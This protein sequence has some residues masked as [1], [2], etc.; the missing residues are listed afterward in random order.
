MPAYVTARSNNINWCLA[1]STTAYNST[2]ALVLG[3]ADG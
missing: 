3:R 2:V 1:H